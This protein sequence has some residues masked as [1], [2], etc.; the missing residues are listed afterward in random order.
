MKSKENKDN[1]IDFNWKREYSLVLILN[2][3]YIVIFYFLM[4]IN[5]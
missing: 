1:T 4:K 5:I 3:L 2:A